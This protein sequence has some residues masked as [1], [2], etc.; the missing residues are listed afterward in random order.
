MTIR[1]CAAAR[2]LRTC[3]LAACVATSGGALA[4]D[5]GLTGPSVKVRYGDLNLSNPEGVA[6]LYARIRR[7]AGVVCGTAGGPTVDASRFRKDCRTK[8]IDDAVKSVNNR[9]LTAMHQQKTTRRY[10]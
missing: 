8:A 9:I 7:A 1:T 3:L 2:L 4:A 10:G 6:R 5:A